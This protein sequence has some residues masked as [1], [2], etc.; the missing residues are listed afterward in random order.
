MNLRDVYEKIRKMHNINEG[1]DD[2]RVV[3]ILANMW[4][5]KNVDVPDGSVAI[6]GGGN[7]GKIFIDLLILWNQ[8]SKIGYIIDNY[9][10][11]NSI[12]KIPVIKEKDISKKTIDYVWIFVSTSHEEIEEKMQ[13]NYPSIK[14]VNP[15]KMLSK[16]LEMSKGENLWNYTFER[17]VNWFN[18]K[19]RE[20][21]LSE[22]N[23]KLD[24]SKKIINGYYYICDWYSFFNEINDYITYTNSTEYI[25]LRED[26]SKMLSDVKESLAKRKKRDCI[27]F[28]VDALSKF[29]V[30]DMRKLT[31][32]QKGAITFTE[33]R[34]N[35]AP[36]TKQVFLGLLT[37]W[38]PFENKT[39]NECELDFN[40]GSLLNFLKDECVHFKLISHKYMWMFQKINGYKNWGYDNYLTSEV[41]F[42]G[43]CELL[44]DDSQQLL[45]LH[46]LDTIHDRRTVAY[47]DYLWKEDK[48]YDHYKEQCSR[49]K[50]YTDNILGVYLEVLSNS[51]DIVQIVM[52]DHGRNEKNEYK[53]Q[54]A[55]EKIT[56][57]IPGAWDIQYVSPALIIKNNAMRNIIYDNLTPVSEFY[58]IILGLLND[59]NPFIFLNRGNNMIMEFVPSYSKEWIKLLKQGNNRA[60]GIAAKGIC[61][62]DFMYIN[63]ADGNEYFYEINYD[64]M[65]D[66][67]Y[68]GAIERIIERKVISQSKFIQAI[69][70]DPIFKYHNLEYHDIYNRLAINNK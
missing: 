13:H 70:K 68:A 26:V 50:T 58:K 9:S 1:I 16:Y 15:Y 67:A 66:I 35:T 42:N 5:E 53:L 44:S 20:R 32:W 29:M 51:S 21:R 61:T 25:S 12:M 24:I 22:K 48:I 69:L 38:L 28:L 40:D 11:S 30:K 45:I 47:E 36:H 6:Y 23:T 54:V 56:E 8:I 2:L 3:E 65:K 62:K 63:T 60:W 39:Y 18:E 14:C 34:N 41:L 10:T 31:E 33:Y 19:L 43:F 59:N 64:N 52:G 17:R 27:I 4:F 49:A 37:G 7:N 57:G 46:S 55:V